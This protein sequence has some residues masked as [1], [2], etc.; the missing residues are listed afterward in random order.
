MLQLYKRGI[1]L[2]MGTDAYTNDMLESLKVALCSQRSQNCLPNVGWC[3]V[4][5]MLFRNNAKI[6][7]RYFPDELGVLK[8]G[9]AADIIVMDYKPFTPFSDENIDG[10]MI[11]GMTGRQCHPDDI[12]RRAGLQLAAGKVLM[13][14]RVLVNI[15]EEAENAH[16]LEAAKKLWGDLNHRTY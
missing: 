1:L 12:R 5:D 7:A 8:A 16:I 15:D 10:H 14:D 13:Q 2:G 4:T 11:F 3:E 9:A 6:G